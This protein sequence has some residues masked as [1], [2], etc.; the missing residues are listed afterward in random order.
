MLFIMT[1]CSAVAWCAGAS[2][3]EDSSFAIPFMQEDVCADMLA[4]LLKDPHPVI[5]FQERTL[6]LYKH[7]DCAV[8][9]QWDEIQGLGN[10]GFSQG[11]G[12]NGG[13]C[14]SGLATEERN[15]VTYFSPCVEFLYCSQRVLL[16][17]QYEVLKDSLCE[18]REEN[19]FFRVRL[20]IAKVQRQILAM[21]FSWCA[22][23]RE[24][25]LGC[26]V[27]S[28]YAIDCVESPDF[29]QWALQLEGVRRASFGNL[30]VRKKILSD[31]ITDE[32]ESPNIYCVEP[33][34]L[35]SMIERISFLESIHSKLFQSF[36]VPFSQDVSVGSLGDQRDF[37]ISILR[38][39]V[40]DSFLLKDLRY[41]KKKMSNALTTGDTMSLEWL[42]KACQSIT[43]CDFAIRHTRYIAVSHALR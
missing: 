1:L 43:F 16:K 23:L 19:D 25:I 39:I 13:G 20:L 4:A 10:N 40:V 3:A 14:L 37:P 36:N 17:A 22:A 18:A 27:N 5:R 31:I 2:S 15:V 41:V 26:L 6:A 29:Q 24:E 21:N 34:N 8:N 38:R 7:W 35:P 28:F 42:T 32:G 9:G 33:T 30:E 12:R 11:V